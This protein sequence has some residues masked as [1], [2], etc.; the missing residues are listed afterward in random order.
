[1]S[2]EAQPEAQTIFQN[3]E[4]SQLLAFAS[5]DIKPNKTAVMK[6]NISEALGTKHSII[7]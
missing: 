3:K 1:M 4:I 7:P 5:F 6:I 2:S